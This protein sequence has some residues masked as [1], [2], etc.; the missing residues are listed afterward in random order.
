MAFSGERQPL[1]KFTAGDKNLES[2][3]R[4]ISNLEF[5][6][7]IIFG[8]NRELKNELFNGRRDGKS[9]E[10]WPGADLFKAEKLLTV[11]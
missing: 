11:R 9:E 6:E 2:L 3:L 5:P 7:K 10:G 8:W 1:Q 4:L